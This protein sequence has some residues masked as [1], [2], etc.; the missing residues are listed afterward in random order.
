MLLLLPFMASSTVFGLDF[1]QISIWFFLLGRVRFF[2]ESN[3]KKKK[4]H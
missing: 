2:V 4:K 3:V 1:Y